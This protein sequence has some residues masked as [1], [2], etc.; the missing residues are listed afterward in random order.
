[1]P[2]RPYSPNRLV[3]NVF[4]L[5]GG[6]AFGIALAAL[7]EYRDSTFRTDSEIASALSLP[8]LAVV[9]LMKAEVES[10]ADFRKAMMLN[11]ALASVVLVCMAVV[12]YSFVFMR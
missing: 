3:I 9:P 2:E 6:L 11:A 10:K 8:V 5:L 1:M 4:G 7:L 12:A